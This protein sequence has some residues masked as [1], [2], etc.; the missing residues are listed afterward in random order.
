MKLNP[1]IESLFHQLVDLPREKQLRYF[2]DHQTDPELRRHLESLLAFDGPVTDSVGQL[3]NYQAK[4]AM[5]SAEEFVGEALCGPYRLLRRI[6]EGGMG[7]V[8]V[9]ERPDGLLKR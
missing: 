9:A 5:T 6:G 1:E 2:E 4:L 8:W 7:E 3:V